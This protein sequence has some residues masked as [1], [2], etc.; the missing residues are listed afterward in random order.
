MKGGTVRGR[1]GVVGLIAVATGASAFAADR[2]VGPVADAGP[3]LLAAPQAAADAQDLRGAAMGP[4]PGDGHDGPAALSPPP[5][6]AGP[7]RPSLNLYGVT[8]LIDTPTAEGQPDGQLSLTTGYVAGQLRN[9]LNFQIL[10]F[11]EGT[12]RYSFLPEFGEN[13]G[14]LYDRSF[15]LK[16]LLADEGKHRP[17]IAVGLQDFLGTGVYSG[18]YIV[19]TKHILPELTVSGGV[20][21][22]RFATGGGIANPFGV[23]ADRFKTREDAAN[24]LGSTGQVRFGRFFHGEDMGFFGGL[25]WETPVEGLTFKAEYS[26]DDYARD[27]INSGY[28][29]QIPLNFGLEYRPVEGIELGAYA[30][31]GESFALRA[32]FTGNPLRPAANVDARPGPPPIFPRQRPAPP[33][34]E[35][36]FGPV[37]EAIDAAPAAQGR[38]PAAALAQLDGATVG[39]R[40]AEAEVPADMRAGGTCP[41]DAAR[42]IDAELGV[43]DGVTFRNPDGTPFC[44]VVLREA[45][46][47]HIR[48]AAR[49]LSG[50]DMS[51]ADD[52]AAVAAARDKAIELLAAE[53]L[54]VDRMDLSAERIRLEMTNGRYGSNAQALGRAA[55][56]LASGLPPS[57]EIFEFTLANGGLPAVTVTLRRALVEEHHG[58]PDAAWLSW[59]G[60]ELSDAAPDGRPEPVPG[61]WPAFSWG[62]NPHLPLGLFDPDSPVR[63]DLQLRLSGTVEVAPGLSATGRVS[64]RLFGNLDNTSRVS[65]SVLPHVRSD[66]SEYAKVD[67]PFIDRLT[68]DYVFKATPSVYGRVSAG[69]FESMFGGVGAEVLWKPANQSWGLGADINWVQQRDFDGYFGFQDYNTVTGHGS[70]YWETGWHGLEV[71]VDAGRYLAGDYGA[72]FSVT[73]KF[74]NGW[75]IGGFFTLTDVPFDE[76]GEGSFDKG[77][78]LTIPLDWALPMDTTSRYTTVIRPLTR[79][80]GQRL[81]VSN[82]LYGVVDDADRSALREDWSWFWK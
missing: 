70:L 24:Q 19:A 5:D 49:A 42:R 67:T 54:G 33:D 34:L 74:S 68:A 48:A 66:A 64:Q 25:E 53:G 76:Y 10:P 12:F 15:D 45:G 28:D 73:R 65:D 81:G 20:G 71:Q 38:A 29:A 26:G 56:A 9:T 44:T 82:R 55:A 47:A 14:D 23:I 43:I 46:R 17:A 30:T 16:I 69:L 2:V 60:A 61:R 62:L 13:G 35:S 59:Q 27:G 36:R 72:T 6:E 3:L 52:P 58:A 31:H 7:N 22:G 41:L 18:E 21:W 75:E 51:W 50:W 40:W 79:D 39:P 80:G 11:V 8:G 37:R 77:I 32:T 1:A 57:V 63:A 4:L 78:R